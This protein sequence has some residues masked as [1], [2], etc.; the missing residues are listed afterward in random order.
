MNKI[1][2]RELNHDDIN[3]Y[4]LDGFKNDD[5][6]KFLEIDGKNLTKEKVIEYI[7]LGKKIKSYYMYAICLK[8]NNKQIG[9][10]KIGPI[11]RKH[12]LSDLVT[13]IWDR[14]QWGKG[15]ATVAIKLGNKIAFEKYNIRKLTGGMI[16]DN[17]GS[18]KAYTNA[19]WFIEGELQNHYIIE[20]KLKNRI[21]VSC[22]NPSFNDK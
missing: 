12:M 14:S 7:D 13:V 3:K 8:E 6:I 16:A 4:Y 1:F 9:N 10:L 20:G 21:V 17:I 5:V 18:I 22:F 19:G 15:L 11:N 2:L